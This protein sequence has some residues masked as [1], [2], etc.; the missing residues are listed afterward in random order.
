MHLSFEVATR[1]GTQD[2]EDE[3]VTNAKKS[4]CGEFNLIAVG[5]EGAYSRKNQN[6]RIPTA[7]PEWKMTWTAE[8]VWYIRAKKD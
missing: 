3:L 2:E 7:E 6:G 1:R 5:I 8:P 4:F